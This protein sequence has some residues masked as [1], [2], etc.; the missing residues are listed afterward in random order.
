VHELASTGGAVGQGK[1]F[2][3]GEPDGPCEAT[4]PQ[5]IVINNASK[6]HVG[7]VL[8]KSMQQ[9]MSSSPQSSFKA[10]YMPGFS[11]GML[12]EG[13]Y[14][15]AQGVPSV[16]ES[17]TFRC[18]ALTL[19]GELY[20]VAAGPQCLHASCVRRKALLR[21]CELVDE[22]R[23]EQPIDSAI[24][25]HVQ[26]H[27]AFGPAARG[28]PERA[29]RKH[30]EQPAYQTC[31]DAAAASPALPARQFG[32][33]ATATPS[34]FAF[35]RQPYQVAGLSYGGTGPSA[36]AACAGTKEVFVTSTVHA[37]TI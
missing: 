16:R 21:M 25:R 1:A 13:R 6:A 37:R 27:L 19:A 32:C 33:S 20:E 35:S 12:V 23:V 9:I 36:A 29:R 17:P 22:A 8:L 30:Q 18:A 4:P 11:R 7:C 31:V 28:R 26:P 14:R 24:V 34:D 3:C 5:P 10:S 2:G 15:M